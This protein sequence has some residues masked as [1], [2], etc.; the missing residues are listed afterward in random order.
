MTENRVPKS[1]R[2]GTILC[3][4]ALAW[5][6][7]IPV[8]AEP[9]STNIPAVQIESHPRISEYVAV[10]RPPH[11]GEY[12]VTVTTGTAVSLDSIPDGCGPGSSMSARVVTV[13]DQAPADA[14]VP[15]RS[16]LE[17]ESGRIE[18]GAEHRVVL[19]VNDLHSGTRTITVQLRVGRTVIDRVEWTHEPFA[20]CAP[21]APLPNWSHDP[22]DDA[23][24]GPMPAGPSAHATGRIA[25]TAQ[26][27]TR[28]VLSGTDS[29]E[30]LIERRVLVPESGEFLFTGLMPGH[31][32]LL[33]DTGIVLRHV[34]L[35]DEFPSAHDLDIP[36]A[37]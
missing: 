8:A 4:G 12:T 34:E 18:T 20:V 27:G 10:I 5:T 21:P 31:Y 23:S 25:G 11:T 6:A 19:P 13:T 17:C 2:V 7:A 36:T 33:G 28:I 22:V 16:V 14:P 1:V 32:A 30:H 15:V 37:S 24:T 29:C 35:S 9:V 26:P 3:T